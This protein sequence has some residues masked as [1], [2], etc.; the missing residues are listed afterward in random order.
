MV[1][2]T[3]VRELYSYID[4]IFYNVHTHTL[5]LFAYSLSYVRNHDLYIILPGIVSTQH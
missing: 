3:I 4:K 1:L 2:N 5:H